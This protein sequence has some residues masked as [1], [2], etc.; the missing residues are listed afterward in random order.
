M[1]LHWWVLGAALVWSASCATTRQPIR[2]TPSRVTH[3][4]VKTGGPVRR[5]ALEEYVRGTVLSEFDPPSGHRADVERMLEVQAVIARTYALAHPG[6]HAREGYDLCATTHCQLYQPARLK[7]SMW[8]AAV[9]AAVRA[10]AGVVLWYADAPAKALYHADCGGHTS[11]AEDVWQGQSPPYL[12]ARR[13][14]GP[15]DAAHAGWR[16]EIQAAELARALNRDERTRVGRRLIDLRVVERDRAGRVL[17]VAIQGTRASIVR[18]ADLRH[19]VSGAFGPKAIRSTKF[20]VRRDGSTIVFTGQG[21]GHGVGLCQAGAYA[22]LRAGAR[23]ADV[24][25]RYFPGTTLVAI[26]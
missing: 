17:R 15:A 12:R 21:Y 3:V 6:R 9:D 10:T 25:A 5:V 13:D 11:A 24:L 14:D 16:Y 8:T 20:D 26:R 19:A 1:R 4:R 7:G 23:P 22:R 2:E 18:G